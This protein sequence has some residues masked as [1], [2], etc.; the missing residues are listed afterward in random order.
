[1]SA[2]KRYDVYQLLEESKRDENIVTIEATVVTGFEGAALE[3]CLE[4]CKPMKSCRAQGR[5]FFNVAVE[6]FEKVN[7]SSIALIPH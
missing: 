1:M 6:D 4:K 7:D 5:I 2:Y 3:E